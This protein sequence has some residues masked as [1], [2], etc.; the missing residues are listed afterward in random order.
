[1]PQPGLENQYIA[2]STL[3]LISMC[4]SYSIYIY[5]HTHTFLDECVQPLSIDLL[6]LHTLEFLFKS[7]THYTH[8]C[9]QRT[10]LAT[11][12]SCVT[13]WSASP[14]PP[15]PVTPSPS[16]T[17]YKL[18]TDHSLA[19]L[20]KP[21]TPNPAIA[22]SE[23]SASGRVAFYPVVSF[24]LT[25]YPLWAPPVPPPWALLGTGTAHW[26]NQCL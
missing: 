17:P 3:E 15:F 21:P 16:P 7:W 13:V 24:I 11:S 5:T 23:S 8:N 12:E 20:S 6:I 10:H 19:L 14:N 1:M 25:V 9:P 4:F 22:H 2:V 26:S 18:L